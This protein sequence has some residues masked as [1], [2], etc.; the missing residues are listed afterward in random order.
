MWLMKL[1]I[2]VLVMFQLLVTTMLAQIPAGQDPTNAATIVLNTNSVYSQNRS[3]GWFVFSTKGF[4]NISGN[5]ITL[6]AALL[7]T[8]SKIIQYDR[9]FIK[10]VNLYD[11][12][13]S[14]ISSDT[15][16]WLNDTIQFNVNVQK[17][18]WYYIQTIANYPCDTCVYNEVAEFAMKL[19]MESQTPL[20]ALLAPCFS[21]QHTDG[22]SEIYCC[23]APGSQ[24]CQGDP[25][26]N[27]FQLCEN[28]KIT[29][30]LKC[31]GDIC[32]P[33]YLKYCTS[34]SN[35]L[36]SIG[37]LFTSYTFTFSNIQVP[38]V[39]YVIHSC[40]AAPT[41]TD[42][43]SVQALPSFQ[44]TVYPIPNLTV[45]TT[46]NTICA[47]ESVTLTAS[48]ASSYTWMPGGI[49]SPSI[50][51]SPIVTTSYTVYGMSD[52]S[53]K[54]GLNS[55]VVTINVNPICCIKDIS[56]PVLYNCTLVPVGTPGSSML[57]TTGG[58]YS[59]GLFV[60][61]SVITGLYQVN[62]VLTI[63]TPVTFSLTE[64]VFGEA[65]QVVQNQP[66][67][68][69]R[70]YWHACD[71]NWKGILSKNKLS[72]QH[73]FIED[74]Q[75]A[76]WINNFNNYPGLNIYD[77]IFNK[78][79]T[80][81]QSSASTFVWSNSSNNFAIT[82]C[83]FT[84][85]QLPPPTMA[86]LSSLQLWRQMAAYSFTAIPTYGISNLVGSSI[87]GIPTT[88][89]GQNGVILSFSKYNNGNPLVVGEWN[90]TNPGYN[91]FDRLG[92][93]GV[94]AV[95]GSKVSVI[96]NYFN[97]FAFGP[98]PAGSFHKAVS[99]M[100]SSTLTV[101]N[102]D[103][104][105]TAMTNT[106]VNC[107]SGVFVSANTYFTIS[108]NHFTN[109][110]YAIEIERQHQTF[111]AQNHIQK[112]NFFNCNIDIRT[113]NNT[114]IQLNIHD[115]KSQYTASYFGKA[116]PFINVFAVEPTVSSSVGYTVNAN[117]FR[118]KWN[119]GVYLQNI[120]Q[121]YITNNYIEMA[122]NSNVSVF[123]SNVALENTHNSS[124]TDNTLTANP[125]A[126]SSW[127]HF[128]ILTSLSPNNTIC[129][130]KINKRGI[131]L[132][133]QDFCPS[134]I[135]NN[136]FNNNL[137][138]KALV[139]I[140]KAFNGFTGDI[141]YN[142]GPITHAPAGNIFGNKKTK[143][144]TQYDFTIA[145]TYMSNCFSP[146]PPENIFINPFPPFNNPYVPLVN[147]FD[148]SSCVGGGYT[149]QPSTFPNQIA[150]CQNLPFSQK[151]SNG[152]VKFI[153]YPSAIEPHPI[154]QKNLRKTT[155]EFLSKNQINVST[156]PNGI[157]FVQ[158]E[159]SS[160]TG[161]FLR[162]DSLVEKSVLIQQS[163]L[164][165]QA[166]SINNSV[167]PST[168]SETLL[169]EFNRVFHQ[170]LESDTL[171]T[172]VDVDTLR[173]IAGLCP[174]EYGTVVYQARALLTKYDTLTYV[175]GCELQIP[176][177]SS[178][179]MMGIANREIEELYGVNVY[180]LY[181]NPAKDKIVVW[182]SEK[183]SVYIYDV[184]GKL[185]LYKEAQAKGEI[186]DITDLI[187]GVYAYKIVVN[188]NVVRQ[189]KLV[190]MH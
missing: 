77:V 179:R 22:L 143:F 52:P 175:N 118:G 84:S 61:P 4:N 50:V 47:G 89:R 116:S 108:N 59:N 26:P 1:R 121:A 131:C 55:E 96:G 14:L 60:P 170:F 155:M 190:I 158:T 69:I 186:L 130:N 15:I 102:P 57:P 117:D 39:Y 18:K 141:E 43:A 136:E 23:C 124:V 140:W 157:N 180:P 33:Y 27:I 71:K 10:I 173:Y 93:V 24:N 138:D 8:V 151:L 189:D 111:S 19:I 129:G 162:S 188:G 81:I 185:I 105:S 133:V 146:Q 11:S 68:I 106:F 120:Q 63:N 163:N 164:L 94:S 48:G 72:I 13:L 172:S 161:K 132:K 29:T 20:F 21:I 169:K 42:C 176:S 119:T 12:T 36:V 41:E 79:Y 78:N 110:K 92:N 9:V 147:I 51:V 54:C 76:V 150:T 166:K 90:M 44:F 126:T 142:N 5:V 135:W 99:G 53:A 149:V 107:L 182:S 171:V 35:N 144:S 49:T 152:I 62:G 56:R 75:N 122:Y 74:A 103:L 181:P 98:D 101:G 91:F 184:V 123:C 178:S 37:P 25:C 145:D 40:Y 65:A 112:N 139:G 177:T 100:L 70:S 67:T 134:N 82:N 45:T 34:T 66:I 187:P 6:K 127:N 167:N 38:T 86:D 156:I 87:L 46:T 58:I 159:Y 125:S 32:V 64:V 104:P 80:A 31:D 2:G 128:G 83:L 97:E 115:N 113:T 16:R 28:D 109:N 95:F 7:P 30:Y 85:C 174:F 137:S 114:A 148:P 3:Q 160:N 73:S 183:C 17:D 153:Q 168:I 165:V 154:I 88:I